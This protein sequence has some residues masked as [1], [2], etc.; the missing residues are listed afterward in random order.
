VANTDPPTE[1]GTSRWHRRRAREARRSRTRFVVSFFVAVAVTTAAALWLTGVLD[2]HGANGHPTIAARDPVTTVPRPTTTV[3]TRPKCRSPLT[4]TAPLKLWIGGDSL[5]GSLGPSLGNLAAATGVVAPV[6]DSRVSSGLS[7]PRFFDWPRHA[8]QEM[9][10]LQPEVVAF[11]IGTNDYVVP[12]STSTSTPGTTTTTRAP[13]FSTTTSSTTVP[14]DANQPAWRVQYAA[15]VEQMLQILI[16]PG[17]ERRTVYWIG[18][19]ILKDSRMDA[20]ASQVSEV[21]R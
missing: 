5:A 19:P 13:L 18:A 7:N 9:A 20:G 8:A 16:G 2:N 3:D 4:A 14:I 1:A 17:P 11:I 10:R 6:Y 12:T 21:A 15:E